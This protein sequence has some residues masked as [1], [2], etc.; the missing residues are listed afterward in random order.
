MRGEI[1]HVATAFGDIAYGEQGEGPPALFVHGV[2]LNGYMWRHVIA[3]VADLRRCV[4]VDLL[5]HGATRTEGDDVGFDRQ[6]EMLEAVCAALGLDAVDLVANDSGGGIA[7]IFAAR[8]P[9]RIRSLTLTNCD[10]H[11]NFPPPALDPL[12]GVVRAGHLG[13]LLQGMLS[14]L[15]MAR[16]TL[17]ISYQ[18]PERLTAETIAIY[19]QP[20]VQSERALD[21]VTRF[22]TDMNPETNVAI[23]TALRTLA[24]PALI[25][26]G[27]A[28]PF[29]GV[30]WA[31]WLARTI[32]GAHEPIVISGAKLFFPE[33]RPGEL[34]EPLRAFWLGGANNPVDREGAE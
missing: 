34:I 21:L 29:F 5:G 24:A 6:A 33:E 23:E 4:A 13:P 8:H 20:L 32:P 15:S 1:K 30:Q 22:F 26:W 12:L 16:T 14:D 25:V 10:V 2:L 31:Q 19:L 9:E 3:G 27:D 18:F 11:D 7:Q 28:D 17:S